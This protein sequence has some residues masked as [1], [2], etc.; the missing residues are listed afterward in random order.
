MI[1]HEFKDGGCWFRWPKVR[2]LR[3]QGGGTPLLDAKQLVDTNRK[4]DI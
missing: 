4:R 2:E 1:Q 3:G